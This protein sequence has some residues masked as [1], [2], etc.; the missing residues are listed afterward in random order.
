M[1][2]YCMET[3]GYPGY[4]KLLVHYVEHMASLVTITGK[5]QME[6]FL[7]FSWSDTCHYQAR[8]VAQDSNALAYLCV[9]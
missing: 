9:C 5:R 7:Y 1:E 6:D 8:P 2:S 4:W 3:F